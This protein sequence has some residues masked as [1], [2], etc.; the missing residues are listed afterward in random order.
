MTEF[1]NLPLLRKD[2]IEKRGYQE[3]LVNSFLN[4]GNTLIVAP[5]ALGKTIIAA[6]A[7]AKILE[8]NQ[9]EKILFLAPTKPLAVQHYENL[10]KIINLP[11]EEFVVMTGAISPSKRKPLWKAKI[12]TATPQ[13]VEADIIN[14]IADLKNTG[15]II[16]DEAHH[17]VRGYSYVFIAERYNKIKKDALILGLTASPGATREKIQTICENLFIR[18][19]E[20]KNEKDEDVL[21]YT[22]K[23]EVTWV[24]VSFP[25]E[26]QEIKDNL[27]EFINET[28]QKLKELDVRISTKPNKKHLLLIQQRLMSYHNKNFQTFQAISL[29]SVLIKINHL[30]ELLETQDVKPAIDY[31]KKIKREKTKSSKKI[32]ENLKVQKSMVLL[33]L[34]HEKGTHHPKLKKLEEIVKQ[35][36]EKNDRIIIFSHYRDMAETIRKTLEKQG[37]TAKKFIG[38]ATKGLEKGLTQKKQIQILNDFKQSKFKALVCTSVGEEGLDIPNV[39][40]IIYYEPISSEIRNIQ[41]R[42]RTGR[43]KNGRIIILMTEKTRDEAYYWISKAKEKNMKKLLKEQHELIQNNSNNQIK[44]NTSQLI[45][46]IKQTNKQQTLNNFFDE[47]PEQDKLIIFV[48]QRERSS[49]IIRE[50]TKRDLIIKSKQLKVADYL[51][52]DRLA[53]ERKSGNDFIQSI[54]DGRLFKQAKE[55]KQNFEKPL[56]LIEGEIFGIR[57]VTDNAIRGAL[58]SLILDFNIPI[59]Q[60]RNQEETIETLLMLAKKEQFDNKR[61]ISLRGEKTAMNIEEQQQF[62]IESLPGIGPSMAKSL[63]KHFKSVKKIFNASKQQL[64][65]VEGIGEK[66]AKEIIN[67]ITHNYKEE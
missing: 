23:K 25:K 28:V 27:E 18:N 46:K 9:D 48:D 29:V 20:I 10:K 58:T 4:K 44:Y 66:R 33:D 21:P 60:T 6:Q 14:R 50:L 34:L 16:F 5:T 8:K 41:R 26:F 57:K 56:I 2:V 59:I 51:V 52:S 3:E 12:I 22:H 62:I 65:E 38:Q 49:G 1:V 7:I 40:L 24:K 39:D 45:Q 47:K 17:A 64:K 36:A 15:L 32:L 43:K 67:T 55:L 19:I 54:I 35:E 11:K 30:L 13:T 31:L 53:I 37:I 42:G 63:L 61:E